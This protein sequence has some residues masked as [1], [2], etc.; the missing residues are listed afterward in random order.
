MSD[1]MRKV[2]LQLEQLDYELEQK[3]EGVYEA[4]RTDRWHFLLTENLGGLVFR[5]YI[6]TREDAPVEALHG[7]INDV[8]RQAFVAS[9][10]L[11]EEGDLTV[12]AWWPDTFAG[13]AFERFVQAWNRDLSILGNHP[14]VV[15]LLV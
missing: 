3:E 12:E 14:D 15:D 8:Q 2:R 11:D 13:E 7:M 5:T 6:G 9:L 4:D 1:L 10:Y